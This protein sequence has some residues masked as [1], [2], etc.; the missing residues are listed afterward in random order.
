LHIV[1]NKLAK[2][3]HNSSASYPIAWYGYPNSHA[4][5]IYIYFDLRLFTLLDY[6]W[7]TRCT[8]ASMSITSCPYHALVTSRELKGV[9]LYWSATVRRSKSVR[10]GAGR[11]PAPAE[12]SAHCTW[13]G[14]RFRTWAKKYGWSMRLHYAQTYK[15]LPSPSPIWSLPAGKGLHCPVAPYWPMSPP[16]SR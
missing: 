3:G 7:C 2:V 16:A 11:A 5:S 9:P 14:G 4:T 10:R 13:D 8:C 6:G 12:R 15:K 1:A